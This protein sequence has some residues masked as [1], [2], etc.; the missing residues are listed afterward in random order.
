MS[1]ENFIKDLSWINCIKLRAS[2]GVSNTDRLPLE[3]DNEEMCI[4][5][6]AYSDIPRGMVGIVGRATYDWKNR[7][8][9]VRLWRSCS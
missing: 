9:S 5:D 6:S 2:F 3:D 4:R 7:Y 8:S 1:K